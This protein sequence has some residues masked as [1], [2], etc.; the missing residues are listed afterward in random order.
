LISF[1][2]GSLTAKAVV[3]HS[4]IRYVVK[5]ENFENFNINFLKTASKRLHIG[6]RDLNQLDNKLEALVQ[7]DTDPENIPNHSYS[8]MQKIIQNPQTR[9]QTNQQQ[10]ST[11]VDHAAN[12]KEERSQR[13]QKKIPEDSRRRRASTEQETAIPPS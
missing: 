8:N 11:M 10:Y 7:K 1:D 13:T 5:S 6:A 3:S 4:V 2:I 12:Y 9:C